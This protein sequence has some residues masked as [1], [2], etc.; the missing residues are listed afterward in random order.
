MKILDNA[1]AS[2]FLDFVVFVY[3]L[4]KSLRAWAHNLWSLAWQSILQS[5]YIIYAITITFFNKPNI[6]PYSQQ[7]HDLI[8]AIRAGESP[9]ESRHFNHEPYLVSNRLL[10]LW[11]GSRTYVDQKLNV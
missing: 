9:E 2:R 4:L 6:F 1:H 3:S 10:L 5:M 8:Y 7:V 11:A